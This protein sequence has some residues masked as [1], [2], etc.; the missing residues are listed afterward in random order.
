MTEPTTTTNKPKPAKSRKVMLVRFGRMKTFGVFEH[1]EAHIPKAPT[2]VVVKTEK[3][4]RNGGDHR[5]LDGV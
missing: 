5:V 2:R 3:R 1:E 4:T